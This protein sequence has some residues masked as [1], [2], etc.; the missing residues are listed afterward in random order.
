MIQTNPDLPQGVYFGL[1]SL[2]K[3]L[4]RDSRID[5]I[6][7]NLIFISVLRFVIW[8][9]YVV[10]SAGADSKYF[11]VDLVQL[12]LGVIAEH[13]LETFQPIRQIS[14]GNSGIAMTFEIC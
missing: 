14:G 6:H 10:I 4:I 2:R 8:D 12:K 7:C 11:V 13:L 3:E 1:N 5:F 9:L